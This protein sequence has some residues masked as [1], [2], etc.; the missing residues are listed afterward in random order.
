RRSLAVKARYEE[1]LLPDGDLEVD[2]SPAGQ[3]LGCGDLAGGFLRCHCEG[4]GHDV[5]V[6]FSCKHRSLCPSC[7]TRRMS[8]EA[9]TVVD[10]VLPKRGGPRAAGRAPSPGHPRPGRGTRAY[11]RAEGS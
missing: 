8:S 3:Y 5:L 11:P 4:C 2:V 10:R 1:T 9:V 6:A 7:G